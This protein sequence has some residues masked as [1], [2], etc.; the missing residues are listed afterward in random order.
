MGFWTLEQY[1]QYV[2]KQAKGL[3]Q[4]VQTELVDSPDVLFDSR[5]GNVFVGYESMWRWMNL[6]NIVNLDP[7]NFKF[8]VQAYRKDRDEYF[9]EIKK[10][11]ADMDGKRSGTALLEEIA[12]IPDK[13]LVVSPNR[14]SIFRTGAGVGLLRK[15]ALSRRAGGYGTGANSEIRF[16][17]SQFRDFIWML[18]PASSPDEVLYHEMIHSSRQMR[19]LVDP[20]PVDQGYGNQ[21]EYL[22][23]VL[24]NIYLSEKDPSRRVFRGDHSLKLALLVGMEATWFLRNP[25]HVSMSPRTLMENFRWSQPKFYRALANLDPSP[26]FNWVGE[27]YREAKGNF[28]M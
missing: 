5:Y 17:P 21:E 2:E 26:R 23:V 7:S 4:L 10:L 11:L 28:R 22:A 15:S 1:K 14:D 16:T 25:Q 9:V 18:V 13:N 6:S 12:D 27:Y 3:G 24:T 20:I 19:G 8:L